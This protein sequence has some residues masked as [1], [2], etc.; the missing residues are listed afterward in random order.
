MRNYRNIW[1]NPYEWRFL[2]V[3]IHEQNQLHDFSLLFLIARW[4]SRLL[5]PIILKMGTQAIQ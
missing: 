4:Y 3:K 1:G 2:A 5:G